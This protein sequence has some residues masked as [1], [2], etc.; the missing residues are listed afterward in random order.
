MGFEDLK[1]P[2]HGEACLAD[3]I[4]DYMGWVELEVVTTRP[5]CFSVPIAVP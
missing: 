4:A 1:R 3:M 2:D 5:N